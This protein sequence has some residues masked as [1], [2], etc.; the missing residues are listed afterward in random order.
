MIPVHLLMVFIFLNSFGLQACLIMIYLELNSGDSCQPFGK[1]LWTA[2]RLCFCDC[3][4]VSVCLPPLKFNAIMIA[5]VSVYLF[6]FHFLWNNI[7]SLIFVLKIEKDKKKILNIPRKKTLIVHAKRLLNCHWNTGNISK[8]IFTRN[9]KK[10]QKK[11]KKKNFITETKTIWMNWETFWEVRHWQ[12]MQTVFSG[13]SFHKISMPI[14]FS[15]EYIIS[16]SF[17]E[18]SKRLVRLRKT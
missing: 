18:L 14:L 15:G 12:S 7:S 2:H 6:T 3:I 9:K 4:I 11:K 5:S 16:L 17:A 8:L 1:G 13:G 10:K